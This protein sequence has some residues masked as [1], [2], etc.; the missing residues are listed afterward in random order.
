MSVSIDGGS[1]NSFTGTVTING[2]IKTPVSLNNVFG[3]NSFNFNCDAGLVQYVDCEGMT[4]T[5]S[6]AFSNLIEGNAYMIV[7][8]QGSGNHNITLEAGYWLNDTVFDF[9]TL[10]NDGRCMVTCSYIKG[11]RYYSVKNLTYV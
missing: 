1:K 4:A 3:S 11:V 6:T 5:G 2:Q 10:G 9:T 8:V 7:L